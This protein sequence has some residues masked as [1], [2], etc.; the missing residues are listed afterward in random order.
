MQAF[1]LTTGL[2]LLSRS[3]QHVGLTLLTGLPSSSSREVLDAWDI[4][5]EEL[6][7]VPPD[8]VRALRDAFGR[9]DVDGFWTIWSTAAEAGLL[10]AYCRARC[11]TAAGSAAFLGRGLLRLRGRRLGGSCGWQRC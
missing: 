11:P 7:V 10:D 9:S 6:G 3:G 5:R 4:Y 2:L 1:A 8:V